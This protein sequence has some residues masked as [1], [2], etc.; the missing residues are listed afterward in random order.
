MI[1]RMSPRNSAAA[2]LETRETILRRAI[3]VASLEGL[4]GLT[5]GRLASDLGMSK[6]GV[7]GGFGSKEGLQ[8][9]ALDGAI[10]VFRRDVWAKAKKAEP[11]LGRLLVIC[12]AWITYLDRAAFPGGCFLTAASFEFDGRRGPVRDAVASTFELWLGVLA[13]DAGTAI[14]AGDLPP[15]TDPDQIAFE[16]NAL[17]VGTNQSRQLHG[18]KD[19]GDRALA[20]MHRVLGVQVVSG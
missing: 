9:A 5:I 20:A 10:D 14:E 8:L 12:D 2:A 15:G 11:G 3:D 16:L 18:A 17:A 1:W 7:V 4:E 6:A 19:V 13:A